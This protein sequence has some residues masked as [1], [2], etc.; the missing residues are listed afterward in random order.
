MTAL[1]ATLVF[2]VE[3][4]GA[5]RCVGVGVGIVGVLVIIGPWQYPAL[6]GSLAG[7]LACLVATLCYGFTLRL[8]ARKFLSQ[9]PI[10]RRDVRLPL[11]RRLGGGDARAHAVIAWHAGRPRLAAS[12]LAC[13]RSGCSAPASRTSGTS[14][15]CG[16][17]AR[18]ASTVT[19]VT[20]VVGVALGVLLLGERFSWHEPV[21]AAARAARHPVHAAAHSA[22]ASTAARYS[23]SMADAPSANSP[24]SG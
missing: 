16:R 11:D 15:C 1:M 23:R 12:S 18:R 24:A 22:R 19:Y 7:Q 17:G 13:S 9:R 14:T 20:P 6:T 10:A 8:P 5:G 21:G 2:R 4:L 3:Q